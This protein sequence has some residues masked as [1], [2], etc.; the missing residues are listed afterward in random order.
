MTDYSDNE[1]QRIEGTVAGLPGTV[2]GAH[3][4]GYAPFKGR[5][6]AAKRAK[7]RYAGGNAAGHTTVGGRIFS[8]PLALNRTKSHH[9]RRRWSRSRCPGTAA[10]E[11]DG[12]SPRARRDLFCPFAFQTLRSALGAPIRSKQVKPGQTSGQTSSQI[13]IASQN[14]KNCLSYNKLCVPAQITGQT[15]SNQV[16]PLFPE[17][18]TVAPRP[19]HL[20]ARDA[21]R[22]RTDTMHSKICTLHSFEVRQLKAIQGNSR[23]VKPKFFYFVARAAESLPIFSYL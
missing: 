12:I 14:P 8:Q 23:Q 20:V 22:F 5:A 13:A 15:R 9:L 17:V 21:S 4:V 11:R 6:S 19:R 16:K 1:W 18:V 10:A 7:A 2:S 3:G